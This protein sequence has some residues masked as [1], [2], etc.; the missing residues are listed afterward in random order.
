MICLARRR[1]RNI[2]PMSIA[3]LEPSC[4]PEPAAVWT[5]LPHD[6]AGAHALVYSVHDGAGVPSLPPAAA[7]LVAR[8]FVAERDWG[9]D[10]LARHIAA[11]LGLP[12][13]W[14]L[15]LARSLLDFGRLNGVT[16]P[17]ANHYQRRAV[18]RELAALLDPPS[19]AELA[20]SYDRAEADLQA[21]IAGL[22]K[23]PRPLVLLGIHTFDPIGGDGRGGPATPRPA[24][25]LLHVPESLAPDTYG[26]G[27]VDAL[28]GT[29]AHP[30]LL[31]LLQQE[32]AG[33]GFDAPYNRPYAL[34]EGSVELRSLANLHRLGARRPHALVLEV[35]KDLVFAGSMHEGAFRPEQPRRER[36]EFTAIAKAVAQ[37]VRRFSAVD[38]RWV[39]AH[40]PT[41]R[42]RPSDS[43]LVPPG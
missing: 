40:G 42:T 30:M 36:D 27:F 17:G 15:R 39:W 7:E 38:Q 6:D 13:T 16:A 14:R 43:G 23:Q 5:R 33:A 10:R 18:A 29:T 19:L 1:P 3:P 4:L 11:S 32:L 9:A 31:E 28:A 22:A 26:A 25:S 8:R 20:A 34:P 37:A 24:A 41:L 2:A 12:G 35:R 21:R